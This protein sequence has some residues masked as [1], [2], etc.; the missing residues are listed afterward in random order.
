MG[1]LQ[2]RPV[3]VGRVAYGPL[4]LALGLPGSTGAHLDCRRLGNLGCPLAQR[5]PGSFPGLCFWLCS[6]HWLEAAFCWLTDG[7]PILE[8]R[9]ERPGGRQHP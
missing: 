1:R 5:G 6:P 9:A 8:G 3:W 7:N 2:G 4:G